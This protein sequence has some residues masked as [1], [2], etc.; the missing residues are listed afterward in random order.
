M[1]LTIL[2]LTGKQMKRSIIEASELFDHPSKHVTRN[3]IHKKGVNVSKKKL[4]HHRKAFKNISKK[5][6]LLAKKHRGKKHDSQH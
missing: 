1:N 2:N 4:K 5:H 6:L 3:Y